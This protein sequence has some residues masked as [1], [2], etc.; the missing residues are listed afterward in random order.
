MNQLPIQ[1]LFE[2]LQQAL[3]SH[4]QVIIQAPTGSGKSTALPLSL[5]DWP[6]LSGR[7]LMLEP[8]RVAAR[9]IAHYLAKCLGQ[10]V[11]EKVGYRVRGESRVSESTRLEIVTEGVLSRMIQQDPELTGIELVIFDE[12][13]ERHLTTDLGLALSIEVQGSLRDDLKLVIMSATLEDLPLKSLMPDAVMLESEGRSYPVSLGYRG[14]KPSQDWLE[15]MGQQIVAL[16]QGEAADHFE[17][18]EA[19]RQGT[20]LAFL[21]GQGEIKRLQTYLSQRLSSNEV[22]LC[23]LYGALSAKEQDRALAPCELGRRKIVLS[24]NVAESSLTIDGVTMVVDSGLVRQASF[25]PKNGVTRLGVKRISQ[26]SSVQRAGRAGRIMAGFCLRLW[27]QEEQ[28]RL[29]KAQAPEI[30]LSELTSMALDAAFWGVKQL[31]DLPLLT[32]ADKSNEQQAWQLLRSLALIDSQHKITPQGQAAY[33]LGCHPRLAHMLLEAY[34]HAQLEERPELLALACL[35]AAVLEARGLPKLGVDISRYL[36]FA[37]QGT[38]LAQA[39]VWLR[40]LEVEQ[41]KTLS[42]HIDFKNIAHDANDEDIAFL[43]AL[44]YPDRVAKRRGQN[45]YLLANGTGVTLDESDEMNRHSYLVV[46]DF[47]ETQGRSAGRVYLAC[48]VRPSLF[49]ESLDFLTQ[50]KQLLGWNELQGKIEAQEQQ[51][52]GQIVL[53]SQAIANPD[54]SLIKKAIIAHIR[55]KGLGLLNLN[56]KCIQLQTRLAMARQ[57]QADAAWPDWQDEQLLSNLEDWLEP[58]LDSVKNLQ[59]LKQIDCYD[60]LKSRLDWQQQQELDR[61]LPTS[62][63]M[64]TGTR[65]QIYYD[66]AGRAL[67]RVRL[68]EALGLAQSPVIGAGKLKVTMELLSPAQRPIA[69][70]A[71]LANFWQ[72]PYHEVKKEMRGRYPKHLWPDDPANTEPTKFTK[73]RMLKDN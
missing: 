33:R 25:N 54:A 5:L 65:A 7:I 58:Y 21:P 4:Q 1:S 29:V 45:G 26:A 19:I 64:A 49:D 41:P 31:G 57:F 13:H 16:V 53:T 28:G 22:E 59:Q 73:K 2:P 71:D 61:L 20:I 30:E 8:R 18:S 36:S 35:I 47:Q 50:K 67:M 70:T 3:R 68:Q 62:W 63:P 12:V 14:P 37:C 40:K 32:P 11:G 15:Y 27:P 52:I 17:L 23:C 72:G 69:L 55:Q 39:K 38:N 56:E 42:Q 66:E 9:S 48:A 34:E 46:A 6:E 43:L 51:C 24:T 44:A 10:K 60:L